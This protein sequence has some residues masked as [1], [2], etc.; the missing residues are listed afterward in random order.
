VEQAIVAS[1][2]GPKWGAT[3]NSNYLRCRQLDEWIHIQ[4]FQTGRPWNKIWSRREIDLLRFMYHV[5]IPL[6]IFAN[7][8][9]IEFLCNI[10]C[11]CRS[12]TSGFTCTTGV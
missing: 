4:E 1:V 2:Y 10:K 5:G 6:T 9:S 7:P 8:A 12:R 3:P 11:I